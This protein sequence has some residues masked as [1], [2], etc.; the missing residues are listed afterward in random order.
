MK[1]KKVLMILITLAV[2]ITMAG[3]VSADEYNEG[4]GTGDMEVKY[5]LAQSYVVTI[6]SAVTLSSHGE[7]GVYNDSSR[8]D[9][10]NL[11]IAPA[12]YLHINLKSTNS[13][14]TRGL[15][16]LVNVDSYIKY[17]INKTVSPGTEDDGTLV[18]NDTDILI[19]AAGEGHPDYISV[20]GFAGLGNY[21]TLHFK[22]T[23]EFINNATKS[24]YHTDT[25]TFTF[26]VN[27]NSE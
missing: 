1:L 11:L 8:V 2:V 9:V 16:N 10:T 13:T 4:S 12:N 24:G 7:D 17:Y 18:E 23:Q 3:V 20:R 22:T 27:T 19:V 15:Y 25:L 14:T 5:E 21:T 6:P 26:T